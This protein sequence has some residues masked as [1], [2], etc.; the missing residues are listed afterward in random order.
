M[1]TCWTST[2]LA[3]QCDLGA[4]RRTPF[5]VHVWKSK[6][7]CDTCTVHVQR[8][9]S[10]KRPPAE[11]ASKAEE[12]EEDDEPAY[13]ALPV[14][15]FGRSLSLALGFRSRGGFKWIRLQKQI[16]KILQSTL[17]KQIVKKYLCSNKLRCSSGSLES[18]RVFTNYELWRAIWLYDSV[19]VFLRP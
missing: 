14:R 12:E 16:E 18:A 5:K 6:C 8:T 1:H 7:W 17:Q 13:L 11:D 2:L 3:P 4:F 19:G 15:H 9:P 10:A